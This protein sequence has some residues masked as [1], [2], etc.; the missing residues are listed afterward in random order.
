M[1]DKGG[2]GHMLNAEKNMKWS[3]CL[4]SCLRGWWWQTRFTLIPLMSR[5]KHHQKTPSSSSPPCYHYSSCVIQPPPIYSLSYQSPSHNH[6]AFTRSWL[7]LESRPDSPFDCQPSL[8]T[9]SSSAP[10]MPVKVEFLMFRVGAVAN[11]NPLRSMLFRRSTFVSSSKT[12]QRSRQR[13]RRGIQL[14]WNCLQKSIRF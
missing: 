2:V 7:V 6:P 10:V 3:V 9:Q 11:A 1:G 8:A 5:H 12:N 14:I 13:E 4:C